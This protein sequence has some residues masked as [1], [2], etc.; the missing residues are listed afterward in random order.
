MARIVWIMGTALFI[1]EGSAVI[2]A[3]ILNAECYWENKGIVKL[4]RQ[5][6]HLYSADSDIH[7]GHFRNIPTKL[8]ADYVSGDNQSESHILHASSRTPDMEY[9]ISG[10]KLW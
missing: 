6:Q 10:L 9:E 8:H 1:G 7:T 2:A 5:A 3:S 4:D